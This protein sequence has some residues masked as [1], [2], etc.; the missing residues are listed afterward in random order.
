MANLHGLTNLVA[1]S[2]FVIDGSITENLDDRYLRV[3]FG[4]A[5]GDKGQQGVTGS[6]GHKGDVGPKG[7][8]GQKGLGVKGQKGTSGTGGSLS[9]SDQTWIDNA[10]FNLTQPNTGVAGGITTLR[11]DSD[12]AIRAKNSSGAY[13]RTRYLLTHARLAT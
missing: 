1:D 13:E 2:Y 7:Q 4:G 9:T 5:K 11:F 6:K 10:Q 12:G 3:G 8:K